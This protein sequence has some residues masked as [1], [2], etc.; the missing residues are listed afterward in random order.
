MSVE[1]SKVIAIVTKILGT[2]AKVEVDLNDPAMAEIAGELHKA[3]VRLA[4][5]NEGISVEIPKDGTKVT[6]NRIGAANVNPAPAPKAPTVA[7]P[8]PAARPKPKPSQHTFVVPRMAKDIMDAMLDDASLVC[9]FKGPTGT[10]KTV[11]A[12]YLAD[13]LGYQLYQ[14]NGH[15]GITP[16]AFFGEKTIEIDEKSGQN[17]I[18]F[19]AGTV[20]KAMT[21]GLDEQGNEVG[22]PGLLFIDEAGALPS[23]IAIA[24]NR[25]LESD[26]PRRTITLEMDGGKVVRSHSKFRIILAANTSGRGATDMAES[27]Y[28]AQMDALDIS[29]LNRI[30]LTFRFGYDRNVE[31]HILKEKMAGED[32]EIMKVLKFRDAVRDNIRAG[33]ISSPFSTRTLVNIANAWRIYRNISKAIY[34]SVFEQLLPEER[35]VYNEIAM[36]QFG[37]DILK[38]MVDKDM[39]YM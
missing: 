32:R 6:F 3:R 29:L 36:A 18:T 2:E 38:G 27:V 23:H 39:D 21:A 20:V 11:L 8:A 22:K 7:A 19:K 31:A 14:L 25:L 17:H 9:W 12:H 1:Q 33:R 13:N 10:G 28:T 30:A 5:S 15:A 16:E 34:Y 35:A 37:E 24:L 26:D 4:M